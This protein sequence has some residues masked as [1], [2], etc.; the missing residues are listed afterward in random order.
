MNYPKS[1][2]RKMDELTAEGRSY[3]LVGDLS[4]WRFEWIGRQPKR[5]RAECGARCRDGSPC[6]CQIEGAKRCKRHGG[7]STGPKTVEGRGRLSAANSRR[8][9]LRYAKKMQKDAGRENA[10]REEFNAKIVSGAQR[11]LSNDI[12]EIAQREL[13]RREDR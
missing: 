5:K 13:E 9:G 11:L 6:E 7:L 10:K 4:G 8:K 1:I 2:Q 12:R 3:K